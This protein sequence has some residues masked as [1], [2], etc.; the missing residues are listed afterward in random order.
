MLVA[1]GVLAVPVFL[2]LWWPWLIWGGAP[3]LVTFP[4]AMALVAREPAG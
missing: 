1:N 4:L 3:W 2:Q